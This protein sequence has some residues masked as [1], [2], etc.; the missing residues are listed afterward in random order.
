MYTLF[1]SG[2][3]QVVTTRELILVNLSG[4]ACRSVSLLHFRAVGIIIIII[5]IMLLS[6]RF[7]VSVATWIIQ[8]ALVTPGSSRTVTMKKGGKKFKN[9]TSTQKRSYFPPPRSHLNT[10][11]FCNKMSSLD[12]CP[13]CGR[14]FMNSSE[15]VGGGAVGRLMVRSR[16]LRLPRRTTGGRHQQSTRL[17]SCLVLLT[18]RPVFKLA[19]LRFIFPSRVVHDLSERLHSG[20]LIFIFCCG[21]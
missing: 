19:R 10:F 7:A 15:A 16:S 20:N 5:I 12:L 6:R 8:C 21:M 2:R 9:L 4:F 18:G 14:S 17:Q 3:D 13:K 1:H 11:L